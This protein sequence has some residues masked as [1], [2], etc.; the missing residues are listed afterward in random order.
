ME[1]KKK[2]KVADVTKSPTYADNQP[3]EPCSKYWKE[4]SEILAADISKDPTGGATHFYSPDAMR[5]RGKLPDWAKER[6]RVG[7]NNPQIRD[8]KYRFYRNTPF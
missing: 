2:D 1:K 3:A 8:R 5:P 6:N 7:K 4:A